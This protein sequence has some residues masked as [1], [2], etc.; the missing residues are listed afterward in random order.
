MSDFRE[1]YPNADMS[2]FYYKYGVVTVKI[3]GFGEVDADSSTFLSSPYKSW[4]YSNKKM[5]DKVMSDFKIKFHKG[6]IYTNDTDIGRVEIGDPI[7]FRLSMYHDMWLLG[8]KHRDYPLDS[9]SHLSEAVPNRR[10]KEGADNTRKPRDTTG[11]SDNGWPKIWTSGGKIPDF[12]KG[13]VHH[14]YN[15]YSWTSQDLYPYLDV[16]DYPT[17]N[18]R[19]YVSDK[20]YFMSRLPVLSIESSRSNAIWNDRLDY[21][22]TIFGVY[23][24][25]FCCGVSIGHLTSSDNVH[26]IIT[27]IMRFHLYFTTRRIISRINKG[28]KMSAISR[29]FNAGGIYR[30]SERIPWKFMYKSYK[31]SKGRLLE[32]SY[33]VLENN[34]YKNDYK[35]YVPQ[36]S[37][38]LTQIGLKYIQESVEA[39]VYCVLGAQADTKWSISS[40]GAKSLQTQSA[41]R[42]LV[43][44]TIIQ[45][46]VTVTIISMRKAIKDCNVVLN[47]AISPSIILV[48]SNMVILEKPI[49]GY[50]NI[51]T[52][53]TPDMRFGVN[54]E[55][56]YVGG[57]NG[58][59]KKLHQ[60]DK[61]TQHLSSLSGSQ[62]PCVS[63]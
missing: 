12:P 31:D 44:D 42:Q 9:M 36:K 21:F 41:F 30:R 2:K 48:P 4:L 55:L 47:M 52:S 25:T 27:S 49:P 34:D 6:S 19:V 57:S 60:P 54:S 11:T 16:I 10:L 50:N 53:A 38:G 29:E 63:S 62:T 26:P 24:S 37:T 35:M 17:F 14:H 23:C 15:A 20:D 33:K 46:D 3:P 45:S 61:P 39:Y 32:R 51:L 8:K 7:T 22:Q 59:G 13:K 58:C 5:N 1:E 56:N 18:F 40:G 28:E 43:E